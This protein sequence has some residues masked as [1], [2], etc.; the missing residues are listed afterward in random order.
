M[1]CLSFI[2]SF[3]RLGAK[4]TTTGGNSSRLSLNLAL[5]FPENNTIAMIRIFL[6]LTGLLFLSAPLTAQSPQERQEVIGRF[7]ETQRDRTA[8][9]RAFFQ[10]MPKGGDLHHHFTGSVYAETY[11][12]AIEAE[13]YWLN[14]ETLEVRP[15]KPR[16]RRRDWEQISDLIEEERYDPYRDRLLQRWSIHEYQV[17][18]RR[19]PDDQFFGAFAAFLPAILPAMEAG[20]LEI[21]QRAI[22]ENVSYIETM[23]TGVL[24]PEG[25][26]T[27]PEPADKLMWYIQDRRDVSGLYSL[28][29]I[30]Y[31]DLQEGTMAACAKSYNDMVQK[32]HDSLEM[33]TDT[34]VMRYQNYVLRTKTPTEVFA[35]LALNFESAAGSPI[36]V[37][38]NIVAPEHSPVAVRDY[39]L[40][41][42][43]FRYLSQKYPQVKKAL[44]AGELYLGQTPPEAMTW[45]VRAA[46]AIAGADRIGHGVTLPYENDW[47]QLL[48]TMRRAG[49]PVEINLSS[50][51]FILGVEKEKHPLPLFHQADVPL[52]IST[53]DAGVLR[54]NHSEQ[55]VRLVRDFPDIRYPDIKKMVYNSL[56][57]SFLENRELKQRLLRQLDERFEAFEQKILRWMRSTEKEKD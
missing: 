3:N 1:W 31:E 53:D 47:Q 25:T 16:R 8:T 44:H 52:V 28:L 48:D 24:C 57:Y 40:H 41:M 11:L 19:P 35:D 33:E 7:L 21:K 20:M 10:M 38:V 2:S 30:L 23:F 46:I 34:F 39:W 22:E 54:T 29:D 43:M 49:I 5:D 51:A 55:F 15:D 32:L 27:Y 4:H 26:F 13:N 18:Q 12:Q 14:L 45:H 9:L 42:H 17:H 36:I 37:G 56:T 50:N 6:F